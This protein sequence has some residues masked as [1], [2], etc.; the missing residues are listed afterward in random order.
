M[1]ADGAQEQV[2]HSYFESMGLF[3]PMPTVFFF[4]FFQ[5]NSTNYSFLITITKPQRYLLRESPP[6]ATNPLGGK[7]LKFCTK[8]VDSFG[9]PIF[10]KD[11]L[12]NYKISFA[13]ALKEESDTKTVQHKI[14]YFIFFFF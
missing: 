11:F 4:F 6:I 12:L 2:T 7:H 9:N 3:D 1:K 14:N 13:S 10:A 8:I 5:K